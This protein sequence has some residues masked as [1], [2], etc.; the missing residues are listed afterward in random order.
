MADIT[1]VAGART[2]LTTTALDSLGSATYVVAGTLNNT[3][4]NPLDVL[5]DV[6]V[7]PGNVSSNKQVLVFA[8][9]SLN[10]TNYSSGP[11]SG[12]TA[13]DQPNL[14]LL[15]S[16]PCNTNSTFQRGIFSVAAAFSGALPPYVKIIIKNETGAALAAS[17]HSV[18]YSEIKGVSA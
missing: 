18:Y 3:I 17:G 16:I 1:L 9:A 15:G 14:I 12:T 13:T 11:E 6:G 5:V 8:K 2:E 10:G 7:T 4:N